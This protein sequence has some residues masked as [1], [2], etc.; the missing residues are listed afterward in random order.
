MSAEDLSL[1]LKTQQYVRQ[2]VT[3][4]CHKVDNEVDLSNE[5]KTVYTDRL[6]DLRDELKKIHNEVITLL[7]KLKYSD[8]KIEKAESELDFYNEK[9]QVSLVNV[10]PIIGNLYNPNSSSTSSVGN[11]NNV[12]QSRFKLPEVPLPKFSNEPEEDFHKFIYSFESIVEK[13]NLTPYEKFIFLRKSLDKAPKILI[14]SL[15]VNEQTYATAK[16]L[17]ERAFGSDITKKNAVIRRLSEINF[18]GNDP[19]LFVGEMRTI[20]NSFKSL[21]ISIPEVL[22]YFIWQGM[23]Q[24]FQNQFI[25]M[26]NSNYPNLD[27]IDANIFQAT[28][29]FVRLRLTKS[30]RKED[31]KQNVRD[32]EVSTNAV[33]VNKTSKYAPKACYLCKSDGKPYNHYIGQC[34][35]YNDEKKRTEKIKTLKGCIKCGFLSHETRECHFS[36]TSKCRRCN[37]NHMTFLCLKSVNGKPERAAV[38]SLNITEVQAVS[39]SDS[40]LLPTMT[41]QPAEGNYDIHTLKDGGSQK[42]FILKRVADENRFPVIDKLKLRVHGFVSS[43]VIETAIVRVPLKIGSKQITIDAVV[44]PEINISMKIEGLHKVVNSF[45]NKG[46][47][48]ADKS[49]ETIRNETIDNIQLIIGAQSEH[50]LGLEYFHFGDSCALK[51]WNGLMLTGQV[52]NLRKDIVNLQDLTEDTTYEFSRE[53]MPLPEP[54]GNASS[55]LT[56]TE[57]SQGRVK[58]SVLDEDGNVIESELLKAA[59]EVLNDHCSQLLYDD[60]VQLDEHEFE[61]NTNLVDHVLDKTERT[62]DG[63]LK[64]P[65]M[66]NSRICHRLGRNF[67]LSS[68]ILVTNTRRLKQT[69]RLLSYN[70]V[71]KEQEKM[72]V[73]ERI[74]DLERFKLEHPEYSFIPH[75]GVFKPS[76][77]TTKTRVVFLSNLVENHAGEFVSHNQAMLPGPCM[78]SKILSSLI[79]TRFDKY[80]I[81]F[82]LRKAF[83]QIL[84]PEE[85]QNRLLFLWYK[86]IEIG[87]FSVMAYKNLR[88]TFGLRPSPC[89]LM[90]GLYKMLILDAE[91]DEQKLRDLKKNIYNMMYV[92]N[93]AV[94]CNSETELNWIYNTLPSVFNPYQFEVQQLACNSQ[95]V[96]EG[97]TSNTGEEILDRIKLLGSVW[98]RVNDFIIPLPLKLNAKANTKRTILS[99]INS[100]YDL[101]GVYSPMLNRAKLFLQDIQQNKK[102]DWDTIL[103]QE[104]I[105]TWQNIVK[106]ANATPEIPIKRVVGNRDSN[107]ALVAFLDSSRQLFGIVIYIIDLKNSTVSFLMSKSKVIKKQMQNKSVPALEF[108]A[109]SLATEL[110]MQT[111]QDL[112]GEKVVVPLKVTRLQ[113]FTDSLVSLHWLNNFANSFSKQQKLDVFI[114]NRLKYIEE[115]CQTKSVTFGFT[116]GKTN[117][118]DVVSRPFSYKK[119]RETCFYEGP[120]F[121]TEKPDQVEEYKNVVIPRRYLLE[122]WKT[123]R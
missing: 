57:D 9:L 101:F 3:K 64:M 20:I 61:T 27:Q 105:K 25:Q 121:L 117:P 113:V 43:K 122:A 22:T 23:S 85:D 33:N 2:R 42:N 34:P 44:T 118:A 87:D 56:V 47:E 38:A 18:S 79:S 115:L 28:E 94:T 24:S 11:D 26:C 37:G 4:L 53:N 111:Y 100:V 90:L 7:I 62:S 77:D 81:T 123:C 69:N 36:F 106:Q 30:P 88:L 86:N 97:I 58:S 14:D 82:D 98:D 16:A 39:A 52:E 104:Q 112:C 65:L 35:L 59:E 72:G 60:T 48:L 99:S 29:R 84:L 110:L 76:S 10:Q 19:Y 114:L 96:Q 49:L 17:L 91:N 93:G 54:T 109:L 51:T 116:D 80:M 55:M 41:C 66:W 108:H 95:K 73:I 50:L 63:R 67:Q 102:L 103:P 46:Y 71:F 107:Y 21:N 92:D 68:K 75:M 8:D 120:E 74:T 6:K 78:N 45:L 119:L 83:L 1:T 5:E 40:T 31:K 15:D 12:P 89:I 13:Q 70:E 32:S